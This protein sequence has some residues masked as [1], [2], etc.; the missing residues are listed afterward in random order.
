CRGEFAGKEAAF[1]NWTSRV[2]DGRSQLLNKWSGFAVSGLIHNWMSTLDYRA[3]YYD[4]TVDPTHPECPCRAIFLFW[5]EYILIPIYLRGNCQLTMLVSKHRDAEPLTYAAYHLGFGCVRGSTQR[6][7]VSALRKMFREGRKRHLTITPDGPR[8]PRRK[9]AM[10]AIYLASKLG[11]PLVCMGFGYDRFSRMN[12]WDQ[13]ALPRPFSQ[14]RAVVSP[15]LH[16]PPNLDRQQRETHRQRV[17]DILNRLTDEA[18]D[19]AAS[20]K[21]RPDESRIGKESLAPHQRR[22]MDRDGPR[23]LYLPELPERRDAA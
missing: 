5:H 6:Q 4:P 23:P 20:G 11:M 14:S 9:L 2:F 12:S 19:W 1:M 17:E 8:G 13:F 22:R 15:H 21:R 3:V 10:G 7:G 16:I 18:E